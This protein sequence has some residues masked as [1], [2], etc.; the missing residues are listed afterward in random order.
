[1]KRKELYVR[2][3]SRAGQGA[4]TAANFFVEA[5][6]KLGYVTLGFPDYGA[7]KRGAPVVVYNLISDNKEKILDDPAHLRHLDLV[8]LLDPT[9]VGNELSYADILKGLKDDGLLVINT[10]KKIPSVFNEKFKGKIYHLPATEIAL[11]TVGRNVPNVATIGGLTNILDLDKAKM[12]K[13]MEDSL[14]SVFP[15]KIVEKNMVGFERG[16]KE[17]FEV[18][19]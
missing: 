14:A 16:E 2:W 17:I 3:H 15:E 7:E 6:N 4:V 19:N 5:L 11:D 13:I 10:S 12:K 8:I 1:M 18:T 9:L